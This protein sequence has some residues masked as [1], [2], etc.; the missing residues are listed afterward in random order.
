MRDTVRSYEQLL[1]A[2]FK[3]TLET[4]ALKKA[5]TKEVFQ[6]ILE[7]TAEILTNEFAEK[8]TNNCSEKRP[9]SELNLDIKR[10]QSKYNNIKTNWWNINDR[11]KNGSCLSPEKLTRR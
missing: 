8:N 3:N 4:K 6:A 7:F 1:N 5:P 9:Y 11:Q 2:V 10:L